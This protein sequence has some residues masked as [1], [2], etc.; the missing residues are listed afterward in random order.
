MFASSGIRRGVIG[1]L[2]RIAFALLIT[3]AAAAGSPPS[4]APAEPSPSA[5][6]WDADYFTNLPVIAHDG[7]RFRFYDDLIK[8]KIV[9]INFIYTSCANICPLTTARL[10]EVKERLG[11]AVGRDIFFYS[12]TLDPVTDGP[13]LLAK[14]AETYNAGPGWLFLTGKPDDIDLIRHRLG[15]RSRSLG[16]HRNDVMLGNGRTGDWGRDSLFSDIDQLTKTIRS[17]DPAWRDQIHPL[18]ASSDAGHP[19]SINGTP[20]QAL[21]IKACSA[22]HSIGQGI[23][24]GPD[25]SGVFDRR[26]ISWIEKFLLAP[27]EMRKAKDPI[28]V[29]LDEK[30]PAVSMPNLGLSK[31]DVADLLA[32]LAPLTAAPKQAQ[33]SSEGEAPPH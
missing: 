32:Y 17:M 5:S 21:F 3:V 15:E 29:A 24:V 10:A 33:A 19:S 11:D 4:Q 6:P 30:F 20:G 22:C 18:V 26:E 8:D 2:S 16:E 9:V 13:E 1:K 25:L 7:R 27:D 28:A 31:S 12:I 14:Y 23:I